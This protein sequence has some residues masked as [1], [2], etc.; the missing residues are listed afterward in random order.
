MMKVPGTNQAL[1]LMNTSGEN[2]LSNLKKM[3]DE[4]FKMLSEDKKLRKIF[5]DLGDDDM[6]SIIIDKF[7]EIKMIEEK[8]HPFTY[9]KEI[10]LKKKT[11]EKSYTKLL[12]WVGE[13]HENDSDEVRKCCYEKLDPKIAYSVNEGIQKIIVKTLTYGY[14]FKKAFGGIFII[15]L[16]ICLPVT[17]SVV[18]VTITMI[19]S[20]STVTKASP[21]PI[22]LSIHIAAIG[23]EMTAAAKTTA[24][25]RM[26]PTVTGSTFFMS[27]SKVILCKWAA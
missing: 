24:P 21:K 8:T 27:M 17:V 25:A 26:L 20:T 7:K 15:F 14:F 19:T 16:I 13:Y 10:F 23:T 1:T 11:L 12:H 6:L 3:P 18:V 2:C 5:V 9:I 4:W 22:A